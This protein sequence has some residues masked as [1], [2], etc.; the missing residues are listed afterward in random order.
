MPI[1]WELIKLLYVYSVFM[2]LCLDLCLHMNTCDTVI[3]NKKIDIWSS[4]HFWYRALKILEI[5]SMI[6]GVF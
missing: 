3:Y 6:R 5:S 4:S 1:E 2:R